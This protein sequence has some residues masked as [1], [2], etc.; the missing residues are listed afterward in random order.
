MSSEEA[1]GIF[2]TWGG[3]LGGGEQVFMPFSLTWSGFLAFVLGLSGLIQLLVAL[4][5]NA[6]RFLIF[7]PASPP[8]PPRLALPPTLLSCRHLVKT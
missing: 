1:G 8:P 4:F 7:P 6:T 5:W 3:D 2:V